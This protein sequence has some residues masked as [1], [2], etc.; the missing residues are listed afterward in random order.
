MKLAHD[1]IIGLLGL[2]CTC[3]ISVTEALENATALA[4][5]IDVERLNLTAMGIFTFAFE[6]SSRAIHTSLSSRSSGRKVIRLYGRPS[7]LTS[8][9]RITAYSQDSGIATPSWRSRSGAGALA[10]GLL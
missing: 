1:S 5:G 6:I 10:N 2:T 4:S 9:Q 8:L 3:P 7:K